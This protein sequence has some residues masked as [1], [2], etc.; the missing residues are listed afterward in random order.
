MAPGKERYHPILSINGTNFHQMFRIHTLR[1]YFLYHDNIG[2][3]IVFNVVIRASSFVLD[4]NFTGD[5]SANID[6][7]W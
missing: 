1:Y 4:M 6:R 3:V 2:T 7:P 5:F